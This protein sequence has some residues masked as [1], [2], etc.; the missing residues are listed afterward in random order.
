MHRRH[1]LTRPFLII[2]V[3]EKER[4]WVAPIIENMIETRPTWVWVCKEKTYKFCSKKSNSDRKESI[5]RR[6]IQIERSHI[7][8]DKDRSKIL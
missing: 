7:T 1:S 2:C 3:R 8:R 5:V 6:V 4:V